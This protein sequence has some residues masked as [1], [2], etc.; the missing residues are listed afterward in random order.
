MTAV[1]VSVQSHYSY[2]VFLQ[3]F[4]NVSDIQLSGALKMMIKKAVSLSYWRLPWQVTWLTTPALRLETTSYTTQLWCTA[5][6]IQV[7][8]L[9][10]M[11]SVTTLFLF[12][13]HPHRPHRFLPCFSPP[14]TPPLNWI[15]CYTAPLWE[16]IPLIHYE[17]ALF[18]QS[19]KLVWILHHVHLG[20]LVHAP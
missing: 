13:E 15:K 20:D 4:F 9:D 19:A 12:K 8:A 7:T 17:V 18:A 2:A 6:L 3:I 14:C 11:S 10:S 5:F 16:F 1:S